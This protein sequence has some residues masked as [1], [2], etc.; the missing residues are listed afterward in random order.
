[1]RLLSRRAGCCAK[2]PRSRTRGRVPASPGAVQAACYLAGKRRPE[3]LAV[4]RV[5]DGGQH[6]RIPLFDLGP[7]QQIF[8]SG[9]LRGLG[10]MVSLACAKERNKKGPCCV[11]WLVRLG[12]PLIFFVRPR[13]SLQHET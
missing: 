9:Q 7:L 4:N 12:K 11:E 6:D 13:Y 5:E 8:V 1:M 10:K 3:E 2:A